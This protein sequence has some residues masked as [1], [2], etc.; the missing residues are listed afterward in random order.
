MSWLTDNQLAMDFKTFVQ[1]SNF[2]GVGLGFL[3]AQATL[4]L[5]KTFV[6]ALVMPMIIALRTRSVPKFDIEMFFEAFVVFLVTLL[7]VFVTIK[8]FNLQQKQVPIVAVANTSAGR[9]V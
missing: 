2:A 1:D 7:T 3:S 4:D 5:S 8:I 9:I 6:A